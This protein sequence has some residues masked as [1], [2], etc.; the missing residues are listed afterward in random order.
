M[1][2]IIVTTTWVCAKCKWVQIYLEQGHVVNVTSGFAMSIILSTNL[3]VYRNKSEKDRDKGS[4][5][6][7]DTQE[8]LRRQD[9]WE[10]GEAWAPHHS[11]LKNLLSQ[12]KQVQEE[13]LTCV[14]I[15]CSE[16]ASAW[17]KDGL[18]ILQ[19][20]TGCPPAGEANGDP[21]LTSHIQVHPRC[22][23]DLNG[24]VKQWCF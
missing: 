17:R 21:N 7:E 24:P 3:C 15:V 10:C 2:I 23:V 6:A 19:G 16:D 1:Q 12:P 18:C 5:S 13:M 11:S 9:P 8:P 14:V 20:H 4:H 22:T